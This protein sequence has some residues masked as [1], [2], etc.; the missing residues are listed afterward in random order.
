MLHSFDTDDES[1]DKSCAIFDFMYRWTQDIDFNALETKKRDVV[2]SVVPNLEYLG[3]EIEF[4]KSHIMALD[5][6][7]LVLSHNDLLPGKVILPTY[8]RKHYFRYKQNNKV[9]RL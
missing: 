5:D 1:I 6:E 7:P 3:K 8:R 9:Y 4:I 2:Q